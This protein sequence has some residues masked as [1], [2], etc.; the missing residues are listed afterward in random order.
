MKLYRL[1]PAA[2]ADLEDIWQFTALNWSHR[3]AEDYVSSLFDTFVKLGKNPGLGRRADVV[4]A[5]YRRFRC[6]HHLIFYVQAD[7]GRVEV[8][9]VLH[10]KTDV[11]RHLY[12][13][14]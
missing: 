6:G 1:S 3:Q 11:A 7:D 5:R 13:G 12:D 4:M 10:E 8:V 2:E 14:R 9:R